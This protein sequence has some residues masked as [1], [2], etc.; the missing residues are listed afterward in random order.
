MQVEER[1]NQGIE[2]LISNQRERFEEY[3]TRLP[4]KSELRSLLELSSALRFYGQVDVS[5]ETKERIRSR[6]TLEAR[7][8][9]SQRL[10]VVSA[11]RPVFAWR[12]LIVVA[13]ILA[14]VSSST[15]AMARESLP[16]TPL[17]PVK[18]ALEKGQLLLTFD[19][20]ANLRLKLQ[21]A[22]ERLK[23][24]RKLQEK[25]RYRLIGVPVNLLNETIDEVEADEQAKV[26]AEELKEVKARR[27]VVLLAVLDK[28]PDEA[29]QAIIN[30][31]GRGKRKGVYKKKKKIK[32]EKKQHLPTGRSGQQKDQEVGGKSKL[33]PAFV[34]PS[35]ESGYQESPKGGS[36]SGQAGKVKT[37]QSNQEK[38]GVALEK[39][40][41]GVSGQKPP[42]I[43]AIPQ[44]K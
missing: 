31:L 28:V 29:K 32:I 13:V 30:A 38:R 34:E 11:R 24:I 37:N 5:T 8:R 12:K 6:V 25:G 40:E 33:S 41:S 9:A 35:G 22:E 39:E 4:Y 18:L 17:Y 2:L 19:K 20:K 21:Q 27:E 26:L 42:V 16:G 14:L 7:R 43:P 3:L 36:T 10:P 44:S 15:V 23:E 1:I